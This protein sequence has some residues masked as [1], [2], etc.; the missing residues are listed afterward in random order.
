MLHHFLGCIAAL[1]SLA[2][3]VAIVMPSI[4]KGMLL[5]VPLSFSGV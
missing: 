2:G 3:C 5:S 1:I 4:L